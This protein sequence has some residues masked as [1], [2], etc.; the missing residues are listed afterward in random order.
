MKDKLLKILYDRQKKSEEF[1]E[2]KYP[3]KNHI[4]K[5]SGAEPMDNQS[6]EIGF[7]E[8]LQYAIDILEREE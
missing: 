4:K 7:Y 2:E 1:W 6:W 5:I 8:G 3:D